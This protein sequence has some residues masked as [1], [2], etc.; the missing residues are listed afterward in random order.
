MLSELKSGTFTGGADYDIARGE[1][2]KQ[3]TQWTLLLD[4][5]VTG[6]KVGEDI[7]FAQ[8]FKS[9]ETFTLLSEEQRRKQRPSVATTSPDQ[10]P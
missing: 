3:S 4:S 8:E 2:V 9:T 7:T 1:F 10:T 5:S 6:S